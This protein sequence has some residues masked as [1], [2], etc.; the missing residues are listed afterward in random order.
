M[1]DFVDQVVSLFEILHPLDRI[2]RAGY[3]VRGV[4]EPE[5][6]AAHSHFVALLALL[7]AEEYPD[8]YD[9]GK[10]L[11]MALIHDLSESRL[12][13]IPMPYADAYLKEAK[14]EA[15]Q[16]IFDEMFAAF[17]AKYAEWHRELIEAQTPEAR[18][19]RGLDKAQMMLKVL[20][21]DR[22]RRGRLEE[23]WKNP[24]NFRDYGIEPVSR[25]FDAICTRAGR[26]RPI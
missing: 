18:L 14:E 19:V 23:F 22:E 1:K 16:A 15:E 5:S 21:Y 3:V 7:F 26:T 2:S 8:Q 6:V 10:V 11:A 4:A 9:R 25:L 20:S 12:M 24:G 17:P 13:D